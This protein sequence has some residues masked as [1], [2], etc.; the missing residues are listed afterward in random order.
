MRDPTSRHRPSHPPLRRPKPAT[1]PYIVTF[2]DEVD[3]DSQAAILASVG[4]TEVGSIPQLRMRAVLLPPS[5]EATSLDALRSDTRV[6][7]V[8]RDRARDVE[9]E[10]SDPRYT[11]QWS[12][13]RIGWDLVYPGG[14]PSGSAVVAIL[15]TGADAAA[16]DLAGR[17]LPGAS[18]VEGSPADTDRHGHGTWMAGIVAATTGNGIGIAGIGSPG[19]RVLP[20]TVL[21]DDG[22]GQDSSII[23]G[24][25]YATD[26]GADVILMA[27]SNPSY[28]VALQAAVDYAW[29]HGVVLVAA[30]GNHG[31]TEPSYPGGDRSVIGVSSTDMNDQLAADSNHGPQTFIAAPGVDILTVDRTDAALDPELLPAAGSGYRAISGTSAAAAEVAAAAAVLVA[32][33]SAASN[34]TIVGRLARSAAAVGTR[35]ETGNGRLDLARALADHGVEAVV[36]AGVGGAAQGGP[37]VGPYVAAGVTRTWTGA[38]TDNNWTTPANWG[39]TAP[40]PGDDLVFPAG[41]ARLSNTN[42][43]PAATSFTSITISGTGYTLSGNSVALGATGI[44]GDRGRGD[45]HDQLRDVIRSFRR[46]LRIRRGFHP[47]PGR[48]PQRGRRA[49]QRRSRHADPGRREHLHRRHL[50]QCRSAPGPNECRARHG[51]RSH[52]GRGGRGAGDRWE[53][54]HGRR[55]D[56]AERVGTVFDGCTPRTSPTTT[57]GPV[58]S[59][60]RRPPPSPP[61]AAP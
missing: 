35:D 21:A 12:L 49:H 45:E 3:D 6:Q 41:A 47:H 18:F 27:F 11:E 40:L 15:D 34:G 29:N 25:V 5:I 36:P 61:P 2:A 39:G 55:A 30:N 9:A 13:P 24:I 56:H 8:D 50:H 10:P 22:T 31:S 52:H 42:D 32:A 59:R 23:Q 60:W 53:R 4:A 14:E 51:R 26:S 19:V 57:R 17:L 7:R 1:E 20:V 54:P 37:F 43:F 58:P 38:G 33:D 16:P 28:S 44:D 48:D 46:H